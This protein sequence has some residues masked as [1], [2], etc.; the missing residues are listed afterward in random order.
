MNYVNFERDF[1]VKLG[2]DVV[3]WA[4]DKFINPSEI[5]T[6]LAPLQKLATAL[7]DG[8]CR[9]VRLS[10]AA[11]RAREA[12]YTEK[13]AT[14]AVSVRKEREDKGVPR[15]KRCRTTTDGEEADDDEE[16]PAIQAKRRHPAAGKAVSAPKSAEFIESDDDEN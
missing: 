10:E 7:K 11:H 5:S 15:N 4:H 9:F 8:T 12:A 13:V 14:G 1:V 3:A 16:Q 6:S 2:I